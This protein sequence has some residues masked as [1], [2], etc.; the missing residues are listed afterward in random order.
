VTNDADRDTRITQIIMAAGV[1]YDAASSIVRAAFPDVTEVEIAMGFEKAV[2]RSNHY[3]QNYARAMEASRR[4]DEMA[5]IRAYAEAIIGNG[6]HGELVP[7]LTSEEHEELDRIAVAPRK[8]DRPF[9]DSFAKRHA[10]NY[11]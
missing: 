6:E 9:L 3:R 5:S 2:A 4:G 11:P 1:R 8:D 7:P 10:S